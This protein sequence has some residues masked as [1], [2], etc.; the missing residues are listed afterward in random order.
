MKNER[1]MSF[2]WAHEPCSNVPNECW[3]AM[4]LR[5]NEW[6]GVRSIFNERV[7]WPRCKHNEDQ[8]NQGIFLLKGLCVFPLQQGALRERSEVEGTTEEK[9]V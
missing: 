3:K 2:A 7:C 8:D 4:T 9:S 5:D 6:W 1:H